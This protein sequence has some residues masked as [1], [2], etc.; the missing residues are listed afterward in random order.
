MYKNPVYL[1]RQDQ[2]VRREM[3][4]PHEVTPDEDEVDDDV[5]LDLDGSDG[6]EAEEE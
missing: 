2:Q 6:D 5:L 3:K 1:R 4:R